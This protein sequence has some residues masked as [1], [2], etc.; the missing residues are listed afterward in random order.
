[1]NAIV[2]LL[3]LWKDILIGKELYYPIQLTLPIEWIGSVSCIIQY[4]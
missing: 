4:N 3:K 1:M 2:R